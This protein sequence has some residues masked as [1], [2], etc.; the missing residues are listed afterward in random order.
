MIIKSLLI[1]IT[2]LVIAKTL[3]QLF[4]LWRAWCEWRRDT[5]IDAEVVENPHNEF[6]V[7]DNVPF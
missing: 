5:V 4:A 6:N 2:C 1:A 7:T 3:W